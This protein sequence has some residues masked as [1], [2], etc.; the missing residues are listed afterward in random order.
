VTAVSQSL[1]SSAVSMGF[2][3]VSRQHPLRLSRLLTEREAASFRLLPYIFNP[4]DFRSTTCCSQVE[5]TGTAK[6]A[7]CA[8]SNRDMVRLTS[9]SAPATP[10]RIGDFSM[11]FTNSWGI[12]CGGSSTPRGSSLYLKVSGFVRVHMAVRANDPK[13]PQENSTICHPPEI[14]RRSSSRTFSISRPDKFQF[15]LH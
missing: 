6:L 12:S 13:E 9:R 5:T 8:A 1:K 15:A 3:F 10:S 7:S 4:L 11:G 14:Q 2:N